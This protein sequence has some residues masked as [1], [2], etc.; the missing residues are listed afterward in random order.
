MSDQQNQSNATNA[1]TPTNGG[2]GNAANVAASAAS[3]AGGSRTTPMGNAGESTMR[4][5]AR[6]VTESDVRA[7]LG[8]R[9]RKCLYCNESSCC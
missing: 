2:D 1:I 7:A 5:G 6:P 4:G 9:R 8:K 3:V